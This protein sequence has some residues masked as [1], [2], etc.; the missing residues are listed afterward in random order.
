MH[1]LKLKLTGKLKYSK[2]SCKITT[3]ATFE[4]MFSGILNVVHM[5]MCYDVLLYGAMYCGQKNVP[6]PF[7]SVVNVCSPTTNTNK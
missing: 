1:K 2:L 6:I 3:L 5:C 7:P 4:R